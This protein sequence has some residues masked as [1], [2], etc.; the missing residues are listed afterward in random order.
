MNSW[1]CHKDDLVYFNYKGHEI[2]AKVIRV[3]T[4]TATLISNS[5][6][7]RTGRVSFSLLNEAKGL[8]LVRSDKCFDFERSNIKAQ[9]DLELLLA[10]VKN[11]FSSIY[12]KYFSPEQ[13]KLLENVKIVWGNRI[14]WRKMGSYCR[15]TILKNGKHVFDESD[16][17]DNT[18]ILSKSLMN[19]PEYVI[20][21]VIYHETLHIRYKK[22]DNDFYGLERRYPNFY[23]VR[24]YLSSLCLEIKEYGMLRIN[25]LKTH[26]SWCLKDIEMSEIYSNFGKHNFCSAYCRNQVNLSNTEYYYLTKSTK[27]HKGPMKSSQ[28]K[29]S[30]FLD[31]K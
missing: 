17:R 4:K 1:E 10:K 22:H 2:E 13:L 8:E 9:K 7:F 24:D 21:K 15:V 16:P 28:L 5:Q 20:C 26:C 29:I 18:I 31:K 3:N 6:Y 30:K 14:T 27:I 12:Q 25:K 23:K 19:T 11:E